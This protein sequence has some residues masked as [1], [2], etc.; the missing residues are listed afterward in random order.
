MGFDDVADGARLFFQRRF[1]RSVDFKDQ[2]GG[3]RR[4]QLQVT[5]LG[6]GSQADVVNQFGGRG[7][8]VL[9]QHGMDGVAAVVERRK[10]HLHDAAFYRQRN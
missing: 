2:A 6:H 3:Y 7:D 9:L 5:L 8:D 1:V 4:V 10:E